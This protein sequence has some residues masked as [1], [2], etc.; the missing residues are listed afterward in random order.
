LEIRS[1]LMR[2]AAVGAALVDGD[3][4]RTFTSPT[5][6]STRAYNQALERLRRVQRSRTEIS[7][8]YTYVVSKGKVRFVLDEA[9]AGD[10][11]K[12]GLEGRAHIMEVYPQATPAMVKAARIGVVTADER[13]VTDKWGTYLSGYAPFYDSR[14]RIAGAL[15]VDL[16]LDAYQAHMSRL[17]YA[18]AAGFGI[19]V[20]LSVAIGGLIG[21]AARAELQANRQRESALV[22]L[23]QSNADLV[24]AKQRA[25]HATSTKSAFL[26]AMSHEIRTPMNGVIGMLGLVLDSGLNDKQR[27]WARTASNSAKALLAVIND[28]LDF[29]KIEAGKFGLESL[30]FDLRATLEDTIELLAERAHAKGLELVCLVQPGV[31]DFLRGD[32]GRLR[33]ILL[34]LGGNAIKFTQSGEVVIRASLESTG[35]DSAT[36]RFE[37][38]DTGI[39]VPASA[40]SK[41]FQPFTQADASTARHYG[42]TG[43]GLSICKQLAELMGGTIGLRSVEGAG[44]TFWFTARLEVPKAAAEQMPVRRDLAGVRILLVEENDSSRMMFS[45]AVSKFG[46]DHAEAQDAEQALLLL[47]EASHRGA[48]LEVALI[49]TQLPDQ[50]GFQLAARIKGDPVLQATRIILVASLGLRGHGRT[51]EQVGGS[52]YLTK[53]V[54]ESDLYDCIAAT[55]AGPSDRRLSPAPLIT[56]HVIAAAR[57]RRRARLLLVEDNEVNQMLAVEL[58]EREGY[59]VDVAGNG[60]EALKA[61]DGSEYA[62]VLMD[63]QM[64]G[65]DG[66]EATA[67]IRKNEPAG[68]R[69]PIIAMT[70]ESMQGDRERCLA[71]GM[72]DYISKP[73][74]PDKLLQLVRR[75]LADTGESEPPPE[76]PLPPQT[77]LAEAAASPVNLAQLQSVVGEDM[78]KIRKFLQLFIKAA[79]PALRALDEAVDTRDGAGLRRQAHQVRGSSANVGAEPMAK[80]AAELEHLTPE[81]WSRAEDLRARLWHTYTETRAFALGL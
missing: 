31:P 27:K 75:S 19:A 43:L 9:R 47:R 59:R 41:L 80:L 5:Q 56:R 68:R 69:I 40:Q 44:S 74:E 10:A 26:A 64:P 42:G 55:I 33:Q 73:I 62:L 7:Y 15:G 48:P 50:D 34:N 2:T 81:D 25:E 45:H 37:V 13:F 58:L 57:A 78:G 46:M 52:A 39:G 30:D 18:A 28:I 49:N 54:R 70:A 17:R 72:D 71:A 65:M 21:L 16:R 36:I 22:Q 60:I 14:G 23:T 4:H 67:E 79:E 77:R 8:V 66:Y 32:P 1:D 3:L 61:L 63:C 20:A 12:D 11:D 29:S 76:P 35:A 38:S 53:P 51:T 6:E 24:E